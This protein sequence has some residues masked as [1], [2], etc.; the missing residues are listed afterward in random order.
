[1]NFDGAVCANYFG[2]SDWLN[3]KKH[4]MR[5]LVDDGRPEARRLTTYDIQLL[6]RLESIDYSEITFE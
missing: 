2:N 6:D 3:A 4:N 5:N 1:M